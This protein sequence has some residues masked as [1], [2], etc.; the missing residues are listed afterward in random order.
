MPIISPALAGHDGTEDDRL[1][2]TRVNQIQSWVGKGDLRRLVNEFNNDYAGKQ[3]AL[4]NNIRPV[5]LPPKFEFGDSFLTQDLR[6]SRDFSFGDR[7][8]LTLLGEVFNV[9]NL[10]NLSG[11]SGN[12]LAVGFGQPT[13][14]AT[15]VFG[16]GGP[17]SFQLAARV[18]F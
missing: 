18:S 17:R 7:W 4:G 3:D 6:L 15:Q 13:S 2:G 11:R 12:L 8:R 9:C 16:S 10:A 5:M 1:P 14:R